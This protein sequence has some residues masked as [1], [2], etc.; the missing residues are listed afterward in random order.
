MSDR[1]RTWYCPNCGQRWDHEPHH[2]FCPDCRE[3]GTDERIESY[4]QA[5]LWEARLEDAAMDK[6][7]DDK[8]MS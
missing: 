4:S 2:L 1:S 6:R 7:L 5:E 3:E 8:P